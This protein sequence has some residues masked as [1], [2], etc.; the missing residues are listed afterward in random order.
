MIQS[1]PVK[2][3]TVGVIAVELREPLHRILHILRTRS[4]IRPAAVAGTFRLFD[5]ESVAMVRHELNAIDAKRRS[6]PDQKEATGAT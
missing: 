6:K 3:I 1:S 2:L 5:R 4:Y